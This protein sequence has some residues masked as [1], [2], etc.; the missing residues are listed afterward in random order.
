MSEYTTGEM[1]KLCNI[2]VRTVQYYDTR[3]ILVP[4]RLSDGGRRL[5]SDEDLQKLKVICFLREIGL[6]I[7]SIGEILAEENPQNVISLLLAQQQKTLKE[8]ITERQTQLDT[9]EDML[10]ELKSTNNFSVESITDIAHVMKNKS[11][12]KKVRGITIGVGIVMDIIQVLILVL[13]ITTGNWIPFA[14]GMVA[15]VTAGIAISAYYFKNTAYI[16]PE[17]H[18]VFKPSFKEAFFAKHTPK[19]RKL[20][21]TKCSHKGYCVETYR[22]EK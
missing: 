17:C 16:C 21:C 2:T 6:S 15:V 14:I 19:T 5:Y 3:N 11:K 13:W 1:A 4:S 22:E 18:T 12:L 9:V 10:K 7:N 20:K 8:E